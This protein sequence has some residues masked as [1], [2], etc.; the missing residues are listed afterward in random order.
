[1]TAEFTEEWLTMIDGLHQARRQFSGTRYCDHCRDTW[2][3]GSKRFIDDYRVQ[4]AEVDRLREALRRVM[5]VG[6][7]A[8]VDVAFRALGDEAEWAPFRPGK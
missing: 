1:M 8:A 4:S 5:D 7:R 3:C 2:P 6:D